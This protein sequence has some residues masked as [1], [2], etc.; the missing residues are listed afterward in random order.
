MENTFMRSADIHIVFLA[1]WVF[2]YHPVFKAALPRYASQLRCILR[3]YSLGTNDLFSL[4]MHEHEEI[5]LGAALSYL[6]TF[7]FTKI[8]WSLGLSSLATEVPI[9]AYYGREE[10][11][12]KRLQVCI[13]AKL[14]Y[15][16]SSNETQVQLSPCIFLHSNTASRYLMHTTSF[17]SFSVQ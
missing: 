3:G 4:L 10:E 11:P 16:W 7:R 14:N 17:S 9:F 12:E 5:S 8:G 15:F 13:Q 6:F 1:T 2:W